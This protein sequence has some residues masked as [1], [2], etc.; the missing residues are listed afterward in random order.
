MGPSTVPCG[1]PESTV[2]ENLKKWA[3]N[4][5]MK[6]NATKCYVMSIKKKTHTFYQLGG[7]ILEQVDSNPYGPSTVPCGTPESTVTC[8][9]DS[10]SNVTLI[11]LFVRKFISHLCTGLLIPYWSNLCSRF[12]WGTVSKA[13]EKSNTC[14]YKKGDKHAAENYR[15][16]SLTSVPCMLLE[17]ILCRHMLRH[18][19]KNKLLTTLNHGFRSGCLH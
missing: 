19:E 15:P 9:D 8:W 7:H 1:T 6:F 12:L 3:D 5:G 4:W 16:V 18:L 17:H 10:P 11:F 13:F 2:L 14:I